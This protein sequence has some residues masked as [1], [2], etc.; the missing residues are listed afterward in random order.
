MQIIF[1]MCLGLITYTYLIYPALVMVLAR[2]FSKPTRIAD[3][4]LPPVSMVISAYNEQEVL[5]KKIKNCLALE[6]PPEKID[7]LIGSD[8]STDETN[9]ILENNPHPRL[10]IFYFEERRGKSAVLNDLVPEA[11]GEIVIFSDANS[12]YQPD[13]VKL[14]SRHFSDSSVGGVCGKLNLL[15]PSGSPGGE[16]EGLYWAFENKIKQAEGSLQSVISANGA[17]FA[18]RKALFQPLPTRKPINDDLMITLQILRQRQLVVFEAAAVAEEST[19]PDMESEFIRKARIAALN[20]NALPDLLP[21]LNPRYGFSALALFSHKLLRWFVPA[22]ALGMLISNF[23]LANG[24]G[25][26]P[27]LLIAQGLIYLSAGL[28][29]LGDRIFGRSGV[30]LPFYYLAMGNLALVVGLWRSLFGVQSSAW[31]RLSH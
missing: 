11:E 6:Y 28:G 3:E 7:Y 4:F 12:I 22:F 14:L 25:I 31:K 9:S 10:R 13:A 5:A 17:I 23:L 30:F 18:V 2:I 21:L 20:F 27:G 29:F 24:G 15:N 16:G 1:W 8:G 19:S 26:Y